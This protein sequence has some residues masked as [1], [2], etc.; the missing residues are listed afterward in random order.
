MGGPWPWEWLGQ[1][2]VCVCVCG[3]MWQLH[4]I[5]QHWPTFCLWIREEIFKKMFM[6]KKNIR[7]SS[8]VGCL[9]RHL[10]Q[11]INIWPDF[12]HVWWLQ[13]VIIQT[14]ANVL[15]HSTTVF[16][17]PCPACSTFFWIRCVV[18]GQVNIQNM[19]DRER[20]DPAVFPTHTY[21]Y[22]CGRHGYINGRRT[23]RSRGRFICGR[24]WSIFFLFNLS[25]TFFLFVPSPTSKTA[26][27]IISM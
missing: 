18:L 10:N 11:I 8:L 27:I 6:S 21:F 15:G 2:S 9:S 7:M 19:Q 26:L 3:A 13:C 5:V 17:I 16:F 23:S 20:Q 24:L 25:P 12:R 4:S 14:K 1:R 22:L